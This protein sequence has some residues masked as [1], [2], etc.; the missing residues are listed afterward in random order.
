MPSY[1]I[2][3]FSVAGLNTD[4]NPT[5]L[6]KDFITRSVNLRMQN[7]GLTPFGGHMNIADLPVDAIPHS[8]FFVKSSAGD[9]WF[10]SGK[11][12]VYSYVSAFS[13]VTP[14]FMQTITDE[15][16]WSSGA[17]SGIPLLCH[18]I[19]GPMYMDAASSRFK[20]LPWTNTQTWKQVNQSCNIIVVHKQY[21]FALGL[22]DNGVEKFDGI[23]WS[24]PADVGAVPLNWNP[25][26]TTSV[27]GISALGGNGGK[28]VGGLSLR[29]SLVIYRESGINVVDYVGGQYVWRIRQM[30][31]TVGLLAK[32]AVVDVNGTH[33]FLS[34]GDV[35]SNDGNMIKSIANNRVRSRMNTIDKT[36]YGKAFAVHHSNK[37]EV[38]FCFPMGGNKYSNV[39]F[40][41]NYEYDSWVTRDLPGCLG[42]DIGRLASPSSTWDGSPESWDGSVKTWDDNSTT[43]FDSVLMGIIYNGTT[44][45]FALLDYILGFNSEPYSSIIERTDLAIGGLDTAKIVTRLYP[46]VVG[47]SSVKIQLGS[48]QYPGGP[49]TWKPA[50]DF[51]PNIDRKVDIRSSGVLHAYR[52]MATDVTANFILTGLD[53]EYQMAGKR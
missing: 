44:Y 2:G 27:A 35:F 37:K 17:I 24:T 19:L 10:V 38:W 3:N 13:D 43:P 36:N 7:G 25:L 15:E 1:S 51:Q 11:N 46:H 22:L 41:Y 34:D 52:I 45:K 12:K 47:G 23:R 33:Y 42:A 30:Q 39:A 14:D 29:D 49:V 8:L 26:D 5:D 31:T 20:S 32:D 53:F 18:P 21:L 16:A 28:I 48:Q 6:A 40:I 50:V 9:V 4:I